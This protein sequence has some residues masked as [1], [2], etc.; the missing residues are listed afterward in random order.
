MNKIKN[1]IYFIKNNKFFY[2]I[3]LPLVKLRRIYSLHSFGNF[4]KVFSNVVGGS[5]VVR[6]SNLPGEYEI[7][8][9]SHILKE[10][11]IKK[12]YEPHIVNLISDSAPENLDAINIGANI[13]LYSNL[14]AELIN[15]QR[16]VL[17]I[18]PTPGAFKYLEANIKRNGNCNKIITFNGIATDTPGLSRINVIEGK[19]EYSSVGD[20]THY[21][22]QTH[23]Y[24]SVDV[25]GESIDNLVAKFNLHPGI[26]VMDVEGYENQVLNG[27]QDTIRNYNP[28]IITEL[29]D[30]MLKNNGSNACQVLELLETNGYTV[31]DGATGSINYPFTSGY[32]I[33]RPN[34]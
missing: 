21:A 19:E 25:E 22:V 12:E 31:S 6:V 9:R 29:D 20:I 30:T 5:I 33:A 34:S 17:S 14:L 13:G 18:E 8:S 24:S 23:N 15:S 3:F 7:D 16:K 27:A 2:F 1:I 4:D 10:I 32:I 26:I 11:L 28:I